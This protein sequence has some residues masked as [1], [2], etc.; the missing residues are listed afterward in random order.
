[1]SG[2]KKKEDVVGENTTD[3]IL[4]EI[5]QDKKKLKKSSVLAF[6]ALIAIIALGIAWFVMNNRVKGG[7]G[8]ISAMDDTPF[9]LA[10]VGDR[11]QPEVTYLKDDSGK[12]ILTAG[13]TKNYEE[14]I[15]VK[16]GIHEK[17][18]KTYYTGTSGLAWNLRGQ[19]SFQPGKGGTLE[20][21]VIPKKDNLTSLTITLTTEGYQKESN[22]SKASKV[23]N[24]NIQNLISGHI[25]LFEN[26]DDEYGYTGR[27]GE[28]N[29]LTVK[30]PKDAETGKT[31]FQKN[32]PY[33][34]TVYW[35]W[36]RYFRNYIYTLRSTQEDLFTDKIH[37]NEE[38]NEEYK[39]FV[40]FINNNKIVGTDK[41][42]NGG[43]YFF[44]TKADESDEKIN[45]IENN[46]INNQMSDSVLDACDQYYNQADE[47]IG[48]NVDYIYVEMKVVNS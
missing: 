37:Q 7:S 32:V 24:A 23:T 35:V 14:Y 16:T 42:N 29:E 19:Q 31:V 44:C 8:E 2:E 26:L 18:K 11:Q 15:N 33:K 28:K 13:N 4:E 48:K 1:M 47:Y 12:N 22:G 5:Q 20:F 6:A 36:P 43:K 3:K 25:L 10:S 45:Q 27:L 38:K 39:K 9:L 34:V 41:K 30:A 46:P 17:V 40:A 21:Y